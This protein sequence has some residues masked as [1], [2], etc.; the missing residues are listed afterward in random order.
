MIPHKKTLVFSILCCGLLVVSI[1][2]SV[3]CSALDNETV[4]VTG[5]L[6]LV[7]YNISVTNIGQTTATVTWNTNGNTDSTVEYG[8]TTGYGSMILVVGMT[9]NHTISL[10][11]L[12]PDTV[13]HYHVLS[14]NSDGTSA[15]SADS[16]FTTTGSPITAV[17]TN[18]DH[19]AGPSVSG[20]ET[21]GNGVAS[22]VIEQPQQVAPPEQTNPLQQLLAPPEQLLTG[23]E[24]SLFP[25][26]NPVITTPAAATNSYPIGFTGLIYNINEHGTLY[27]NIGFAEA[28]GADISMYT[29]RVDIYQHHSPGVLLTFW[30]KNLKILNNNITGPVSRAE[31][32][33]DPL[34][35]TLTFGN[36]SGS[37]HA[38]LPSIYNRFSINLSISENTT[39]YTQNQFRGI[40]SR[41]GLQ[42]DAVAYTFNVQT[43]NLTTGLA[44]VTFT[45]P[46]SWVDGHGGK[47]AVRI[48]RIGEEIGDEQ[49]L[50][51]P[52]YGGVDAQ[53]N[54][55]YRGDS[56]N[57]TSLYGLVTAEKTTASQKGHQNGGTSV[58][59]VNTSMYN[60]V[61]PAGAI[62]LLLAVIAYFGWWKKRLRR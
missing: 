37:A 3:P 55:I 51:N 13:Y 45:L 29:D 32:V 48:I 60:L 8:T 61:V 34:N 18:N 56:P 57:C 11:R 33:T 35:A 9:E 24:E 2:L 47:D 58:G 17:P 14:V 28:A 39:T 44:N 59:P 16:T 52:V 7:N 12:S 54:M 49:E 42:L 19:P 21:S 22:P 36:V 4:T 38:A 23:L 25:A 30:G 20:G 15:I 62:V 43:G 27:V 6:L 46:A 41:N 53:G 40:L 10:S 31:F 5:N 1:F 50:I 26:N